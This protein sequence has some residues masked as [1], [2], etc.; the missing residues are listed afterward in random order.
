MLA[1]SLPSSGKHAARLFPH[2]ESQAMNTESL[3]RT[4]ASLPFRTCERT[5]YFQTLVN[6]AHRNCATVHEVEY[7]AEDLGFHVSH[8]N[9]VLFRFLEPVLKK[10]IEE[11]RAA[12]EDGSVGREL[13]PLHD[14][15][16]IRIL[17]QKW[18]NC[19]RNK[20]FLSRLQARRTV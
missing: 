11:W 2:S 4:I 12:R 10:I 7:N 14:E 8:R 5:D 15:S 18:G 1:D 17:L 9:I 20:R 3:L 19:N 16:D 6:N 13:V